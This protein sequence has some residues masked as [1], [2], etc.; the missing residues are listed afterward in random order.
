MKHE[1]MYVDGVK[2]HV[3]IVEYSNR[4]TIAGFADVPGLRVVTAV[5]GTEDKVRIMLRYKIRKAWR[6]RGET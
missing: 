2:I 1:I 6:E 4:A 3:Q 5:S